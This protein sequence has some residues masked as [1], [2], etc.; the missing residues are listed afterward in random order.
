MQVMQVNK[1]RLELCGS[2]LAAMGILALGL[3]PT[4]VASTIV[5]RLRG[6]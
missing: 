3:Q 5:Q 1:T 4:A 6:A 2:K